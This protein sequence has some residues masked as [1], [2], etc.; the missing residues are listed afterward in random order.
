MNN[1][2]KK[3]EI[4]LFLLILFSLMKIVLAQEF[5][6]GNILENSN[7]PN[8]ELIGISNNL[9][10]KSNF[11]LNSDLDIIDEDKITVENEDENDVNIY[12]SNRDF[13]DLSI[14][15][16]YYN[17]T[18]GEIRV[19]ISNI[20]DR[21]SIAFMIKII[22]TNSNILLLE[23][24]NYLKYDESK[25]FNYTIENNL[26]KIIAFV[27]YYNN[28]E[29]INESNNFAH[30]TEKVFGNFT[31]NVSKNVSTNLTEIMDENM[32][33]NN[34]NQSLNLG[35]INKTKK[36][37]L[38]KNKLKKI[39]RERKIKMEKEEIFCFKYFN[40]NRRLLFDQPTHKATVD[41]L[42]PNQSQCH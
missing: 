26:S 22:D 24:I 15:I 20:G 9:L 30:W 19:N 2:I 13:S 38:I 40:K 3:R 21:D 41:R 6:E 31:I 25:I 23:L 39:N 16:N 17:I 27:D 5:Y 14:S 36:I 8:Y 29:E 18:N 35:L 28:I 10:N 34:T 11:I 4:I 33:L 42:E 12:Y 37:E 1:E 32:T 7:Y